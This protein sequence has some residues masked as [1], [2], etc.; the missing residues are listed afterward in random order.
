MSV[1]TTTNR[2]A[3]AGN[4]VT[5]AFS[6]PYYFQAQGDLRGEPAECLALGIDD[7]PVPAN[8]S[9]FCEYSTHY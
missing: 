4:G 2:V 9:G 5:T 3:F 8:G 1:S 7:K 6:F